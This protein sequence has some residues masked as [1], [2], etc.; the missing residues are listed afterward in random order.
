MERWKGRVA[1]VTGASSGIGAEI[2]RVFVQHGLK[3][4][5]LSNKVENIQVIYLFLSQCYP[6]FYELTVYR[7]ETPC[8]LGVYSNFGIL[9]MFYKIKNLIYCDDDTLF[10]PF[11]TC[12]LLKV[13]V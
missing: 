8:S 11:K 10:A 1:L 9:A 4:F 2:C 7:R 6:S 3:V 12:S 5:G 13:H